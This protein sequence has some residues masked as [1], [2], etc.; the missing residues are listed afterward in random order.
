MY[1]LKKERGNGNGRIEREWRVTLLRDDHDV[2]EIWMEWG[3]EV[4]RM[5][6][7]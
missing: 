1:I 3:E 7:H 6:Y 2:K 4:S 5:E